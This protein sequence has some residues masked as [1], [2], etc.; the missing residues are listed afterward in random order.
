M[1]KFGIF[2]IA[3]VLG[4]G[5]IAH[6][7]I[8]LPLANINTNTCESIQKTVLLLSSPQVLVQSECSPYSPGGY[9]SREGRYYDYRLTSQVTFL[10]DLP[11]GASA[12][13]GFI[14]TNNC[15]R[16]QTIVSML[17]SEQAVVSAVCSEYTPGGFGSDN[18]RKYD[19][20]LYTTVTRMY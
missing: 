13:L 10:G 12:S 6:A 14:N 1:K 20:R 11:V 17:N 2:A 19:Y 3:G 8:T 18:G 9:R 15:V 4:T 7:D 5:S 16:A